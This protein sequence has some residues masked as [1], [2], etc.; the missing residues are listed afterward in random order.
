MKKIL[1]IDDEKEYCEKLKAQLHTQGDGN[2]VDFANSANDYFEP[3]DSGKS[4]KEI[5]DT[6][7]YAYIFIH[8]SINDT[9]LPE[10]VFSA[11]KN[12]IG[13]NKLFVFSGGSNN[14]IKEHKFNREELY[15]NFIAFVEFQIAFGDWYIPI[16]YYG[17]YKKRYTKK[18]IEEIR[19]LENI[20]FL[21]E[22]NAYKNI[23]KL[24]NFSNNTYKNYSDL[25]HFIEILITKTE[26]KWK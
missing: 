15:K 22:N 17:D 3:I 2:S 9:K 26:K 4:V 23:C 14:V 20:N 5:K 25:S 24:L 13:K 7:N 19:K 12:L 16:L 1:F 6:M 10:T 8:K 18:M 11:I 21:G